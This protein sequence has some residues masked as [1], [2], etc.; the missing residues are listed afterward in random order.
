MS[1]VI[2]SNYK[3]EHFLVP[4]IK[5]LF[6]F[7]LFWAKIYSSMIILRCIPVEVEQVAVIFGGFDPSSGNSLR[8]AEVCI[9]RLNSWTSIEQKTRVFFSM[10]FTVPST[11]KL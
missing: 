1:V 4:N 5:I 7:W 8:T 3:F 9:Q 6:W 10:L 2:D 11:C